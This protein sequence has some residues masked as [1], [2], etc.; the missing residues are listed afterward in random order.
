ME[1]ICFTSKQCKVQHTAAKVNIETLTSHIHSGLGA[2]SFSLMRAARATNTISIT[3]VFMACCC[4]INV[5]DAAAFPRSR[6]YNNPSND[7]CC[8]MLTDISFDPPIKHLL[9]SG[10]V[11]TM[12][13]FS[14]SNASTACYK[15][16]GYHQVTSSS[17]CRRHR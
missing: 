13:H 2:A 4:G 6:F 5:V 12:S 14:Q 3:A 1:V 16:I 10:W 11:F 7:K 15:F 9:L 17:I 8:S